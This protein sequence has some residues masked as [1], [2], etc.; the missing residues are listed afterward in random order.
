MASA[1]YPWDCMGV[2]VRFGGNFLWRFYV[3]APLPPSR[4][5]YQGPIQHGRRGNTRH[6]ILCDCLAL[7]RAQ[8]TTLAGKGH[9]T[10]CD[11]STLAPLFLT[12]TR[13]PRLW[14]R[15]GLQP[16]LSCNGVYPTRLHT[17]HILTLGGIIINPLRILGSSRFRPCLASQGPIV[18][19]ALQ[20]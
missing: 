10:V 5:Q 2:F 7:C 16:K 13:K 18:T 20:L 9:R 1:D 12:T 6:R 19:R 4:G 11:G 8:N 15:S 3:P 14:Y 17:F